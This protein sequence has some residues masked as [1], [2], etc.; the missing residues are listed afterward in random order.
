ML[1]ERRLRGIDVKPCAQSEVIGSVRIVGHAFTA[2]AGIRRHNGNPMF[3]RIALGTRLGH[4]IL[5]RAGQP[6]Q[7]PKHRH[8]AVFACGGMKIDAVISQLQASLLCENWIWSPSKQ[9]LLALVSIAV[10]IVL[11]AGSIVSPA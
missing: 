9:R 5:I 6:G 3:C 7:P 1:V 11:P 4:E 2:R 10:I 8:L